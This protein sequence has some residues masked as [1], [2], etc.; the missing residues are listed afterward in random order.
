MTATISTA[1]AVKSPAFSPASNCGGSAQPISGAKSFGRALAKKKSSSGPNSSV[2]F[3]M[4]EGGAFWAD[5]AEAPA[6]SVMGGD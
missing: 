2:S 5:G 6:G 3:T 4:G 1:V